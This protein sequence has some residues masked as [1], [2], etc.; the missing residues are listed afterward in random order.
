[1]H[2]CFLPTQILNKTHPRSSNIQHTLHITPQ[3]TPLTPH[4]THSH[5]HPHHCLTSCAG[6]IHGLSPHALFTSPVEGDNTP[7]GVV[8]SFAAHLREIQRKCPATFGSFPSGNIHTNQMTY[9]NKMTYPTHYRLPLC[10]SNDTMHPYNVIHTTPTVSHRYYIMP[11][12]LSPFLS[13]NILSTH[14]LNPPYQ[15][16]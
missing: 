9:P 15:A 16:C 14:P 10:L 2:L 8:P 5:H 6:D 3:I 7:G 4:T 11:L 12:L 13:Y 1:M